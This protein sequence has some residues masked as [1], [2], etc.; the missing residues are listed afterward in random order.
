MKN[1]L[2]V[3]PRFTSRVISARARS[4]S[5]RTRVDTWVVASLTRSPIDGSAGRIFGSVNGID[6]MV[7]GTPF[8]QSP[9]L[10]YFPSPVAS[11]VD[12]YVATRRRASHPARRECDTQV[13]D[14]VLGN[15]QFL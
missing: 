9:L 4:T 12:G 6:V 1:T 3:R 7:F 14:V 10:T 15:I 8:L 11:P 2:P 5:A 13:T